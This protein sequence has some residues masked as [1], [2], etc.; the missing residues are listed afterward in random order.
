MKLIVVENYDELSKKAAETIKE[1]VKEKVNSVLGLA[2]GSTPEGMYAELVQKY[3]NGEIDFENIKT[4]NLDEYFGL[5]EKNE[6]SY[7]YFMNK[8][9]FSKVNIKIENTYIPSGTT[10]DPEKTGQDY[11]QNILENG[12]IDIQ[13]LGIGENGH[14]GF[15]EPNDFFVG[16]THKVSLTD[17]TIK[18]NSRFFNSIEEVP[19][20]A[21]TM[22]MKSIMGAKKILLLAS[23]KK[24]ADAIYNTI[25]GK[26]TPRVPSSI[27]QLHNNLIVIVDREAASKL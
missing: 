4:F 1:Q 5:D 22:G 2:T 15:N 8:H 17:E 12:G 18:A 24:K 16:P 19:T 21:I 10:N 13:V 23:G 11:D 6:Q 27:L 9:L 7:K 25:R 14:I 20:E 26:I 3:N